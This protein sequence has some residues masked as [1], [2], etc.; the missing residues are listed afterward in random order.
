MLRSVS[1]YLRDRWKVVAV[2]TIRT[3]ETFADARERRE[4]ENQSFL[5]LK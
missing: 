2:I 3:C 4:S 1:K 5:S